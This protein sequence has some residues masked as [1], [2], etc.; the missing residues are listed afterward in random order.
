MADI[1]KKICTM[2]LTLTY[3]CVNCF[4]FEYIAIVAVFCHTFQHDDYEQN[5]FTKNEERCN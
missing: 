2:F 1:V 4:S 3:Q 5:L